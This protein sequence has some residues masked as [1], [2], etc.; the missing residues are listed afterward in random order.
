[1]RIRDIILSLHYINYFSH[2]YFFSVFWK[3]CVANIKALQRV[4]Y[5]GAYSKRKIERNKFFLN[6]HKKLGKIILLKYSQSM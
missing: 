1:M 3:N 2:L 5:L 4:F 6:V